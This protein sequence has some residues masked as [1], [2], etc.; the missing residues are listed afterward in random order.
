M[1]SISM[2]YVGAMMFINMI[3]IY[4]HWDLHSQRPQEYNK[5]WEEASPEAERSGSSE[6]TDV[7]AAEGREGR[8][9]DQVAE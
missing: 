7:I 3:I 8:Q 6:K 5:L 1:V 9:V 4:S 2:L